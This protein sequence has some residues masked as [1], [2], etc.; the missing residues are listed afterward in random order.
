MLKT[1]AAFAAGEGGTI[2]F[3]VN[4]DEVTITGLG[5]QDPGKLRDQ[6]DNLIHAAVSPVPPG[7]VRHYEIDGRLILVLDVK[8]GRAR[9]MRSYQSLACATSRS[10]TYG[11]APARIARSRTISARQWRDPFP[12]VPTADQLPS[13]RR[14]PGGLAL[15]P[16]SRS[17]GVAGAPI[18]TTK[19]GRREG[20]PLP[21]ATGCSGHLA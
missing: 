15:K 5:A 1:V 21:A 14:D 10:S 17:T 20:D 3:G 16:E 13:A 19:T 4:R 9:L 8:T 12:A 2:I 11:V 18:P 7:N 6:L